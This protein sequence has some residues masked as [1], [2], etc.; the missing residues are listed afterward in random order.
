MNTIFFSK[1]LVSII[2]PAYNAEKYISQ[3]L[4]SVIAQTYTNIEIIVINDGSKDATEKL[5]KEYA[6]RDKRIVY[7][8]QSNKGPSAARNY[9]IQKSLGE[10]ICLLD[11][12]DIV[13][14]NKVRDQVDFMFS[15]PE[16]DFTYSGLYYFMDG[17]F[18]VYSHTMPTPQT[19]LVER[20]LLEYGNFINPNTVLFK[21][22]LFDRYG[23][24]DESLQGAEEFELWIRFAAHGVMFLFQNK[25][26]TYYRIRL[27]SHSSD[28]LMM[29]LSAL[30]VFSRQS[31]VYKNNSKYMYMINKQ[32]LKYKTL[33][34]I[35]YLRKGERIKARKIKYNNFFLDSVSLLVSLCPS[36][37]INKLFTFLKRNKFK[38]TYIKNNSKLV[39]DLLRSIISH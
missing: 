6:F 38:N 19:S 37:F 39:E 12:D 28:G 23:G 31:D 35:A 26:L 33:T 7:L 2:I 27:N 36:W 8:V 14:P 21:K 3:T 17:T 29:A 15:H 34:K 30:A 32:L 22:E 11:S 1:K 13:V 4:D 9:G 10:Y 25:Y 16:C 18:H 24:F 20:T 5:V